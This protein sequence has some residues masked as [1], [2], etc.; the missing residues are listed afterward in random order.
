[1]CS[2]FNRAKVRVATTAR[3]TTGRSIG[4]AVQQRKQAL[5]SH[6]QRH[7]LLYRNASVWQGGRWDGT[8]IAL[9]GG[10]TSE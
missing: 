3:H 9:N 10:T 4:D 8:C 2:E 5:E 1:M 7:R 6:P